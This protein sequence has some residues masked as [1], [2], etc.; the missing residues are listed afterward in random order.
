MAKSDPGH[1]V[2]IDETASI[3]RALVVHP[4]LK[5][6]ER[7]AFRAPEARLEEAVG[8]AEAIQLDVVHSEV[9]RLAKLRPATLIGKGM[10]ETL[11]VIIEDQEVGIVIVDAAVTPVQQRNLE[12]VWKC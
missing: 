6:T 1:A 3:G 9:V 10:V 4:H 7:A 8:L 11:A 12:R 5:S 2:M